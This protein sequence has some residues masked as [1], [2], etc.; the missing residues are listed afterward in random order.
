M[1]ACLEGMNSGSAIIFI[2]IL[3]GDGI[4]PFAKSY[5][6]SAGSLHGRRVASPGR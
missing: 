2:N 1:Y 6:G 3:E 4:E 5:R